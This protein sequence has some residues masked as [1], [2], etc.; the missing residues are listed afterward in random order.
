MN[1]CTRT[2]YHVSVTVLGAQPC[3]R[4][5]PRAHSGSPRA[6]SPNAT[7]RIR[8]CSWSTC[9]CHPGRGALPVK[10]ARMWWARSV[11]RLA[12]RGEGRN[13]RQGRDRQGRRRAEVKPGETPHCHGRFP[14]P[15]HLFGRRLLGR[16]SLAAFPSP[17]RA[18]P[19]LRRQSRTGCEPPSMRL[20][21]TVSA[22]SR[23]RA[24][25]DRGAHR[26][27]DRRRDRPSQARGH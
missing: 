16:L 18:P 11:S 12:R 27:H 3:A 15:A 10:S 2:G 9:Q 13:L 7:R 14:M 5:T 8:S 20:M 25:G 22:W 24:E 23:D 21:P 4:L 1:T 26:R 17:L 19:G 6:R